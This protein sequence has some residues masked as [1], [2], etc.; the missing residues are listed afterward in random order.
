MTEELSVQHFGESWAGRLKEILRSPNFQALGQYLARE[1][2]AHIV[3][4]AA[5]DMFK[6]FRLCPWDKLKVVILGQDCYHNGMAS[7]LAFAN[8]VPA[9]LGDTISPS[10]RVILD[11][12]VKCVYGG[13]NELKTAYNL[14][15]W[16]EQGV[17][18]LNSALTV[19]KG[20][21][22][23]H[24]RDW[25]WFTRT[26]LN[27]INCNAP[28]TIYCLWGKHAKGFRDA[29]EEPAWNHILEYDHPAYA[30]YANLEWTGGE[31]FN[32]INRILE[33][34]NGIGATI[35]W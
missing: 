6:A 8:D 29:I 30:A 26:V 33:A 9:E 14:E 22:G 12:I 24:V 31:C 7:G 4:P 21:P 13:S 17:L 16:A 10:L 18:L 32:E 25:R 5:K 3:Y 20:E 11:S 28:G 27:Y 35:T 1:R 15:Y 2:Q 34:S 23:S 19:R